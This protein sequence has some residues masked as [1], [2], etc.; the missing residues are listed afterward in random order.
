MSKREW[1]EDPW[2]HAE[3]ARKPVTPPTTFYSSTGYQTAKAG[4][5][6]QTLSPNL[7]RTL[8]S[9]V[10]KQVDAAVNDAFQR[11]MDR[12]DEL[13]ELIERA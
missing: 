12:L 4:Y 10:R 5:Q 8:E 7:I 1:D 6:L 13:Q 2:D 3:D 11:I 9:I